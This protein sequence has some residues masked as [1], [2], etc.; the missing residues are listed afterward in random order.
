MSEYLF[1]ILQPKLDDVLFLGKNYE[2][3]FDTFEVFF[4][5][6][7][8]DLN[9]LRENYCWG[10]PGR[11][12]WKYRGHNDNGPLGRIISEGRTQQDSWAPLQAGLFGGDYTRFDNVATQLT[13]EISRYGWS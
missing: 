11:F 13:A 3:A 5:L 12:A 1:K 2:Q 4:A 10:P 8:A 9:L 6:A 7:V